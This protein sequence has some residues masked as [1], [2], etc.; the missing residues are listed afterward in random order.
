MRITEGR[1]RQ[2]IRREIMASRLNEARVGA[3]TAYDRD[4][5]SPKR[6]F[7]TVLRER[8]R[9]LGPNMLGTIRQ[10]SHDHLRMIEE[11]LDEAGIF[12]SRLRTL[13]SGPFKL[14]PPHFMLR[15]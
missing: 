13:V 3:G 11:A 4:F 5:E 1:L 8:A 2:I 12:D 15:M 9:Q 6:A 14:I 10:G 7:E